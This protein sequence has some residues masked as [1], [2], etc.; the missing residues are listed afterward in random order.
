MRRVPE[1]L[2]LSLGRRAVGVVNCA[3]VVAAVDISAARVYLRRTSS[4]L[5]KM[6]VKTIRGTVGPL[7]MFCLFVSSLGHLRSK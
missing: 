7:G 3:I 1:R 2:H 4:I 5:R 6:K